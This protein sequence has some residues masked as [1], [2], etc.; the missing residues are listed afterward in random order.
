MR[1][2]FCIQLLAM[3]LV[4][5]A[6]VS[7][8]PASTVTPIAI[9][10]QGM[11]A[12]LP[13]R[14]TS[15]PEGQSTDL[16]IPYSGILP[17]GS[18]GLLGLGSVSTSVSPDGAYFAIWSD[19][20]AMLYDFATLEP[21]WSQAKPG[22]AVT[23]LAGGEHVAIGRIV[24]NIRTGSM[25][26]ASAAT[27]TAASRWAPGGSVIAMPGSSSSILLLEAYSGLE[28]H[29]LEL[30]PSLR[31][32]LPADVPDYNQIDI[33]FSPDGRLVAATYVWKLSDD[34][35]GDSNTL[36]V[37][38]T[39]T[40]KLLR[41]LSPARGDAGDHTGVSWSPD[42]KRVAATSASDLY[43]W[44]VETGDVLKEFAG[45][46]YISWAPD[47]SR[48]ATSA[49]SM[50]SG[51]EPVTPAHVWDSETFADVYAINRA[52][53]P[54]LWSSDGL[55]LAST[56]YSA[57]TRSMVWN[58]ETGREAASVSDSQQLV[59][60]SHDAKKIMGSIYYSYEP[61]DVNTLAVWTIDGSTAAP[62]AVFRGTSSLVDVAW[63]PDGKLI[64]GEM[65]WKCSPGLTIWNVKTASAR[66]LLD[67]N[68]LG[69]HSGL[70]LIDMDWAPNGVTL[71]LSSEGREGFF[72][73]ADSLSV[74][75]SD[76][77]TGMIAYNPTDSMTLAHDHDAQVDVLLV[78]DGKVVQTLTLDQVVVTQM[79]WSPDG[80]RIALATI[81]KE[82]IG[83]D[84]DLTGEALT[85]KIVV[86][87][88]RSNEVV[89]TLDGVAGLPYSVAWSPDGREI[90]AGFNIDILGI[91]NVATGTL[92]RWLNGDIKQHTGMGYV[93]V[94]WSPDGIYI[95]AAYGKPA[96]L[97]NCGRCSY[98]VPGRVV[99]WDAGLGS[100]VSRFAA[101]S[102]EVQAVAFSPDSRL[103][104]SGSL[105][106]SIIL[107]DV[108]ARLGEKPGDE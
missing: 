34:Y 106:G 29:R 23:W 99:L 1:A 24:W 50:R 73:N 91:W 90:V 97:R 58:A 62:T 103:L 18:V 78:T 11:A 4:E 88:F 46:Q 47:G 107:W 105:D 20:E 36:A 22:G 37:W 6:M 68:A 38:D 45:A 17:E 40:G 82:A 70:E 69:L 85:G 7:C 75:N 89:A 55:Q 53:G 61:S 86:W 10:A 48:F 101:H 59:G 83:D 27:V 5:S 39:D 87:D 66:S 96:F 2:K 108:N 19:K 80:T 35:L 54:I 102:S 28:I 25:V 64:A 9:P 44:N 71:A 41:T 15:V 16:P 12:T 93:D 3:L 51:E 42:S 104:A 57:T 79:R 21:M 84:G 74:E 60:F 49:A 43:L 56:S 76:S 65:G 95:G 98:G 30:P 33:S 8:A 52:D 92:V 32:L 63:S 13:S 14:P 31:A 67:R 94:D 26:L 81:P 100:R 77:L 72:V